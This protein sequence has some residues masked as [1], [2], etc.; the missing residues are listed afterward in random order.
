M[1]RKTLVV[2]MALFLLAS[3]AAAADYIAD[4]KAAMALVKARKY[5]EAIVAF[6]KMAEGK[7]TDVQKSDALEQAALA[8]SRAKQYDR[9]MELAQQ[10]PL[11]PVSKTTQMQIMSDNRKWKEVVA[12]FKEEDIDKW[13]DSVKARAFAVRGGSA[14]HTRDGKLA[15]A[16][17]RKAVEYTTNQNDKGLV[18][19]ALGDTYQHLL[20][21]D[22][23]ALETYRR[24]YKESHIYKQGHAAMAISGILI[25][26]KKLD[27]AIQEMQKIDVSKMQG[28]YWPAAIRA[29]HAR[30]LA[31]AGKKDEAVAKY[32]EALQVKDLRPYLKKSYEKALKALEGEGK[33]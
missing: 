10:V 28:N 33:K 12:T 26:Q 17:F 25:K 23:K 13:P 11:V 6:T 2:G 16:D 22:E 4:R 8:A 21:D 15:E 24:V 5:E 9:A 18:L 19:N 14:Y 32:K 27:E 31:A 29:A 1:L 3:M 20:K 7:V 30:A